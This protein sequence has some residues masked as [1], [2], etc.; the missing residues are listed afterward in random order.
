MATVD[1]HAGIIGA[2]A[3]LHVEDGAR[4]GWGDT[5]MDIECMKVFYAVQAPAAGIVRL[6]RVA[7]GQVVGESDIVATVE[8]E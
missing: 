8:T 6:G 2:V 3:M 1:V 7:L 5:I 4:V